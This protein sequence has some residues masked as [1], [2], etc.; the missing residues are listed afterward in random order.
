MHS[1]S[2]I[3]PDG[4]LRFL[5]IRMPDGEIT[6]GFE[7]YPW[8][9]HGDTVAAFASD[10]LEAAA[11]RFVGDLLS[12]KSVI[13]VSTAAGTIRNVWITEDPAQE[14]KHCEPGQTLEFRLWD[15]TKVDA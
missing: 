4:Q 6:M 3:S 15:G 12:G 7:G 10:S 13:A 8:H 2:H 9:T 11:E 1:E 14:R 5:V